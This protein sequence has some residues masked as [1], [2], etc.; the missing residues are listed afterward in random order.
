MTQ[1]KA[2][3]GTFGQLNLKTAPL[4]DNAGIGASFPGN[5]DGKLSSL[6]SGGDDAEN[7]LPEAGGKSGT[8]FL[9][10]V[11]PQVTK[12]LEETP[13]NGFD[14]P[15]Y[16]KTA[17]DGEGDFA[18]KLHAVLQMYI[19]A[20]DPKDK[21][22]Y[23][24]QL[25]AAYWNLLGSVARKAAGNIPAAKKYL[26][27]FAILHPGFLK[28]EQRDFFA[29]VIVEKN[30][31]VPFYYLDEWFDA[32]GNGIVPPSAADEGPMAGRNRASANLCELLEKAE[33]KLNGAKNMLLKRGAERDNL[34]N[35]FKARAL[36]ITEH[37]PEGGFPGIGSCYTDDQ[38]KTLA[39]TQEIIRL[40]LKSD[41]EL[42][43]ALKEFSETG[44]TIQVLKDKIKKEGNIP[45]VNSAAINTEFGTIRQMAKMTIGRQG[46]HFPVCTS[47]YLRCGPNDTA[48][49]ENVISMLAKIESIDTECFCR[50][51]RNKINRIVPYVILIPA[52]GDTGICWE[53]FDRYDRVASR[54]RI[55]VPLYPKNLAIALLSA[56]ADLRWQTAK[57]KA[58]FYWMEEG[59]TGNYYQWYRSGKFKGD[60]KT[61][62]IQDY[63]IW[64]TKEAEG[65]QKLEKEVRGIFWRYMPFAQDVKERLKGR[66]IVYQELCQRDLNRA[67][68]DGY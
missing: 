31:D 40:M 50:V 55:A 13:H 52:Y 66:N 47:E 11:L 15:A 16:Y 29:K 63:I 30:P 26:L 44:E 37:A 60:I 6:F 42:R 39:A 57:E 7:A 12:K 49:R 62:F 8:D 58:S 43:T 36:S 53:P 10:A 1:N 17:L 32:V 3:D 25:P 38:K 23:R 24:Q 27:R 35:T 18:Q 65:I 5:E 22:V 20:K 45:E 56:V 64:M 46:N 68:S 33:R 2:Q 34:E 41:Q 21:A 14:D 59:L 67:A 9:A 61:Y 48:T 51:H 19:N 54:G 28:S 4:P